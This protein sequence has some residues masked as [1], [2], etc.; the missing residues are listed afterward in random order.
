MEMAILLRANSGQDS[1][2]VLAETA[3]EYNIS[4]EVIA[5]AVKKEFA[6]RE[7]ARAEKKTG[8]RTAPPIKLKKTA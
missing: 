8:A 1:N 2:R 3:K 4:V 6:A 7:K 5:A